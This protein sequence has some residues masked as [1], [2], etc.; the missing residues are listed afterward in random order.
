M[1][2]PAPLT[3]TTRG[4]GEVVAAALDHGAHRLLLGLGDSAS[5][6]GGAGLLS[7]L[8]LRLTD[9]RWRRLSYGGGELSN[10]VARRSPARWMR[11]AAERTAQALTR[12]SPPR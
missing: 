1:R 3:A 8:G 10:A 4:T 5:T 9:A 2:H 12:P 7:A 11:A 6:D